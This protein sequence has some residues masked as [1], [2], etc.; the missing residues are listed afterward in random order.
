MTAALQEIETL[1]LRAVWDT[2]TEDTFEGL[3]NIPTGN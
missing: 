3:I 2:M 1:V